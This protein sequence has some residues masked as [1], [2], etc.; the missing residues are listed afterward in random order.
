[1]QNFFFVDIL[2]LTVCMSLTLSNIDFFKLSLHGG[3]GGGGDGKWSRPVTSQLFIRL[4][5]NL[6]H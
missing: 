1:M 3:W 4:K 5:H 6:A 2:C